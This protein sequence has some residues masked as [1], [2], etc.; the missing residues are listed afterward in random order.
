[1]RI[2][3]KGIEARGEAKQKLNRETAWERKESYNGST[4]ESKEG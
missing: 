4:R 1:M 3:W 2:H